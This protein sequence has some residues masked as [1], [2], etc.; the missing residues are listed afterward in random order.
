M[1][2][3]NIVFKLNL[4]A[5]LLFCFTANAQLT[6]TKTI[7]GASPDYATFTAARTALTSQ[8]VGAGGVTFRVRN[9]TY[10]EQISIG[11]VANASA[12][13]PIVFTS[14]SGNPNDVVLTFSATATGTN[15]VLQLNGVSFVTFRDMTLTATG[16]S[17]ARVIDV[18]ASHNCRFINLTM[19]GRTIS[20]TSNNYAV[21]YHRMPSAGNGN[22]DKIFIDNCR[23]NYGSDGV[24]YYGASSGVTSIDLTIQNSTFTD[25]YYTGFYYYYGQGLMTIHNN[26][27]T[28][29]VTYTSYRGMYCYWHRMTVDGER[30]VITNNVI[31]GGRGGY[32]MYL[33]YLGVNSSINAN[34]RHLIA[35][36]MIEIGSSN[37]IAYGLYLGNNTDADVIHNSINV[38][39][40]LIGSTAV[41]A[42]LESA[43][44][45]SSRISV[46]NNNFIGSNGAAAIRYG[47]GAD[48]MNNFNP[49][50][51]NNVFS[52][53][54]TL[55]YLGTNPIASNLFQYRSAMNRDLNS[56]SIDPQFY[57]NTDLRV[58]NHAL[59]KASYSSLVPRDYYGTN[60]NASFPTIGA[61]ELPQITRRINEVTAITA[62][63]R[64]VFQNTTHNEIICTN[65][66]VSGTLGTATFSA[67]EFNFNTTG[68]TSLSDITNAKLFFTGQSPN[69]TTANQYGTTIATP[70][71]SLNFAGNRTLVYGSNYFCLS[72]DIPASASLGNFLDA[73]FLN[74][75]IDSSGSVSVK[76]PAVSNPA[77]NRL[78]GLRMAGVY[79]IDPAGSGPR[80]FVSFSSAASNLD[81]FGVSADVTFNVASS[82]FNEQIVLPEIPTAS[83]NKRIS[84]V[85]NGQTNTIITWS[86]NF[87][88]ITF[89]GGD[90][91]TLRDLTVRNTGTSNACALFFT[92]NANYNIVENCSLGVA[93]TTSSSVYN[94]VFSSAMSF[95]GNGTHGNYNK[96]NNNTIDGGYA[97]VRMQG[98]NSTSVTTG[99]L[100]GNEFVNNLFRQQNYYGIYCY[101]SAET[102]IENNRFLAY[103]SRNANSRLFDYYYNVKSRVQGNFIEPHYFGIYI[104]GENTAARTERSIFANNVITN[105]TLATN[106]VGVFSAYSYNTDIVNNSIWLDGS[107]ASS[108]TN[109]CAITIQYPYVVSVKNNIIHSTNGNLAIGILSNST[110]YTVD[111]D[112]NIYNCSPTSTM[113]YFN[114]YFTSFINYRNYV[115]YGVHDINSMHNVDAGII[116]KS[117]HHLR[118]GFS[119]YKGALYSILKTDMD[120]DTRCAFET[121][122]GTDEPSGRIK[123]TIGFMAYDTMCYLTPVQIRNLANQDDLFAA[124]WFVNNVKVS[125]E[126]HLTHSFNSAGSNMVQL[127]MQTCYETDTVSKS[128]FIQQST[129]P[130]LAEFMTFSNVVETGDKVELIDLTD[131]CPTAWTWNILPATY[132][133]PSTMINEPTHGYVSGT[134]INSRS[135]VIVFHYPGEY[136]VELTTS[137]SIGTSPKETKTDFIF[138]KPSLNMCGSLKVSDRLYGALH[139]KGGLTGNYNEN[140]SCTFLIKPCGDRVEI[141]FA[142][143]DLG[144]EA[145]L[146]IWD[147]AS[148]RGIPLWNTQAYPYGLTGT[149]ANSNFDTFLHAT[150]SG[151]VFVEFVSGDKNTRPGFRL[152]WS[153]IGKGN[154][155]QPIASFTADDTGC[156]VTPF[157]LENTSQHDHRIVRYM[158]DYTGNGTIDDEE[159]HGVFRTVFSGFIAEYMPRLIVETCA[160]RDTFERKI[161]LIN[162]ES[163]PTGTFEADVLRP[164]INQDIVTLS[165]IPDKGSCV[166]KWQWSI[167]PA[168]FYFANGT[169]QFSEFPQVVFTKLDTFN[170]TL[171]IGNTNVQRASSVTKQK[172]I[173][174]K[175]FCIPGTMMLHS[176]IGISRVKVGDI[177]NYSDVGESGY[178]NFTNIGAA[179]FVMN[180]SYQILVERNTIFNEMSRYV[181]IDLNND[182]VFDHPGELMA[183]EDS[184]N[185]FKWTGNITIPAT[186]VLGATRMRIGAV[187]VASTNEPCNVVRYGEFEDYRVIIRA[188]DVPPVITLLGG[189]VSYVEIGYPFNDPGATA[190]DNVEGDISSRIVSSS[191]V[192]IRNVGVYR[193]LYEVCDTINNCATER[194]TVFVTA[195]N[196]PPVITM[197]GGDPLFVNVNVPFVDN[198]YSA[199]DLADGD[200][201]NKVVI[202]HNVDPYQLGNY[203]I[204]YRVTDNAGLFDVKSRAVVVVDIESPQISLLGPNTMYVEIMKPFIDPGV[205]YSDNYWAKERISYVVRGLVDTTKTGT[206]Y[207]SYE[208]TDASG[209]GPNSVSRT[210]IV[211]DSTAPTIELAGP[212]EVIV[213]VNEAWEDPGLI[214]T[215]NSYTGFKYIVTG[216]LY[217]LFPPVNDKIT[218]TVTGVYTVFYQAE[219]AS[220]NKSGLVP[221]VVVVVDNKCPEL[222][223][224]GDDFVQIERWENYVDSGYIV[225]DNYYPLEKVVV[226]TF[227]NVNIHDE[228][229]YQVRYTASDPSNRNCPA[230][231]RVVRVVYNNV[232]IDE[233]ASGKLSVYPNPSSGNVNVLIDLPKGEDVVVSI[234]NLLGEEILKLNSGVLNTNKFIV[235]MSKYSAGIYLVKVQTSNQTILERIVLTK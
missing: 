234:V 198:N 177:D 30:C 62:S 213:N 61:F 97:G 195:D 80:N 8:G 153:S 206:Y 170:V 34:R 146:R 67:L 219:D 202:T 115:A 173:I 192:D 210:V 78:I 96:F 137:N 166:N 152:E 24:H 185:T 84:F 57:S 37:T 71:A 197:T 125:S 43:Y 120:G 187:Y 40:A 68:T 88:T 55:V 189:N 107:T 214:I 204:S 140:D 221:R 48:V 156:V 160:G 224:K 64:A 212:D 174:P 230:V 184:A 25:Q 201:T 45:T 205:S 121:M 102:V 28:T 63:Q 180:Q 26:I 85:G 33:Q 106:Q 98:T 73:Q 79:T 178:S 112:F 225:S 196:T 46:I 22:S 179:T 171:I 186:A 144:E 148:R 20:T 103:A 56:I 172:Y 100:W 194:R 135:P 138:V 19:N 181:W 10:T 89:N 132:M 215:D 233:N 92:N 143:F 32:G 29:N 114:S 222:T 122:I 110:S 159:I 95:T 127:V 42:Q 139:D 77:G 208:V 93:I 101:Y 118:S 87:G 14:E 7:G 223:L 169:D 111:V 99:Y 216:T 191:T 104:Y 38:T 52:T 18:Y 155:P 11:T 72:Y 231:V 229:I 163:T 1:K 193:V 228:G 6:G 60:R 151:M 168:D 133:N 145:Y 90:Y 81:Q 23:I 232:S 109:G 124:N 53:G 58:Y 108:Y 209:N 39:S 141:K 2:S 65:V 200:I 16:A 15:Y 17:F 59:Q 4:I 12:A 158:W 235:D 142:Q 129:N 226:E 203:L 162:P 70:G 51:F 74:V 123:P 105:F 154:F 134:N 35:N 161:T 54:T 76:N 117:D 175:E 150:Q 21:F 164:V 44:Q 220:G 211:W 3:F 41:A 5:L 86:G 227:S 199:F 31:T 27:F 69:F 83:A 36:N 183:K 113:F 218:P 49:S 82:T 188:D 217:E 9:G 94:I 66:E 130:P 207:L 116:S 149:M 128:V 13:R 50:N 157:Y 176:D 131:F 91:Y 165:C 167:S 47:T 182:G 136:T 75:R 126:T 119:G 190:W 147:G